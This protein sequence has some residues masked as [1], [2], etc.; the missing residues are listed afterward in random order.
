ML[1]NNVSN[2]HLFK[3]HI[4]FQNILHII[5]G[6]GGVLLEER[7]KGFIFTQE[8]LQLET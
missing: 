8:V 3:I 4:S 5:M 1:Q 7:G 2:A 6:K